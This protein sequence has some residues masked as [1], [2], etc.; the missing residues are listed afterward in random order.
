MPT[1]TLKYLFK[2]ELIPIMD[3]VSLLEIHFLNFFT[4]HSLRRI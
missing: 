4:L 3:F 2:R 1:I